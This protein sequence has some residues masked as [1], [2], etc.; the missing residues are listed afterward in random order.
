M[1]TNSCDLS[2]NPLQG[3]A[4]LFP[5][6]NP[7]VSPA[8]LGLMEATGVLSEQGWTPMH[9]SSVDAD[10]IKAWLPL[11]LKR[12]SI[13]EFVHDW[14]WADAYH[15][16]GLAYYPKL[17]SCVPFTPVSGPRFLAG[18]ET[19]LHL[20]QVKQLSSL[21]IDAVHR[22]RLSSWHC[23]FHTE[24]E[25]QALMELGLLGRNGVQFHWFNRGYRDFQDFLDAL[26]SRRRKEIR[27]ERRQAAESGLEFV[28]RDGNSA[29]TAEWQ[30]F[31]RFYCST[32]DRKW[33][34]PRFSEL[35][36]RTLA[37]ASPES[38]LLFLALR[39]GRPVAGA[40]ALRGHDTLYGRHW[41]CDAFFPQLHFE[42]CYYQ[43]IEYCIREGLVRLDAG[44]QGE[45]KLARGFEAVVTRSAHYIRE[46]AFRAAVA[47]Y[48]R[49]ESE[50][51]ERYRDECNAHSPFRSSQPGPAE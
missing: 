29:S 12:D 24:A 22:L 2:D 36:F 30:A 15:R 41:G 28:V 1:G 13:G 19:A 46:P 9:Q 16:A 48:C 10:L 5:P 26:T 3:L 32:F 21:A 7:I 20:P 40:F 44:A 50:A 34:E 6:G 11:Y 43:T 25:H 38:T 4:S 47:D 23:L 35:Y 18:G 17:V 8:F 33:G 39:E 27:R 14:N 45:H 49:R 51:L 37:S 42:L 31:H